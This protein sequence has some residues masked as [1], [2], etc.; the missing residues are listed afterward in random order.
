VSAPLLEFIFDNGTE[1][2]DIQYV[3]YSSMTADSHIAWKFKEIYSG[4]EMY[5]LL[6]FYDTANGLVVTDNPASEFA[7]LFSTVTMKTFASTVTVTA[8]SV[9]PSE[10]TVTFM[11]VAGDVLATVRTV[12]RYIPSGSI[13]GAPQINQRPFLRWTNVQGYQLDEIITSDVTFLPLYSY[14]PNFIVNTDDITPS[15]TQ[16]QTSVTDVL[17]DNAALITVGGIA[18]VLFLLLITRRHK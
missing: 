9:T 12:G 3:V 5:D 6:N 11:T 8:G 2:M 10:F 13:P 14:D 18:I 4:G 15:D 7:G 1:H 17:K 16:A